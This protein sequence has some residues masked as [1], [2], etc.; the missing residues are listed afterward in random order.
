[1]KKR[2]LAAIMSLCMVVSLLPVSA[3]AAGNEGEVT[4][5]KTWEQVDG[6]KS[7]T[8]EITLSVQGEPIPTTTESAADVVLV[9]DN[10]GSMA[11]GV[12]EPCGTPNEEFEKHTFLGTGYYECPNCHAIYVSILGFASLPDICTGEIGGEARIITAQKVGK[13][14]ASS[15]L[16]TGQNKMAVIGFSHGN[17][18][19][20]ANDQRAIKVSQ[21]LTND[22]DEINEAIDDMEANGGTNYSAALQQAYSWL[23]E[24]SDADKENRPAYV[25]FISDGAPGYSGESVNDPDWNGSKQA[26]ALKA[27]GVTVYTIG[28]ALSD[29][30]SQYLESLASEPTSEHYLNVTGTNYAEELEKILIEWADK[31]NSIPAGKNAVM[32]DVINSEYFE[33][34]QGSLSDGLEIDI[35]SDPTGNTL[36]WDIGNIPESGQVSF[37]IK[38]KDELL[39]EISV[40]GQKVLTNDGVTLTYDSNLPEGGS[41]KLDE[42]VIGEPE[43]TIYGTK[44][45][46]PTFTSSKAPVT[47]GT[48]T[49]TAPDQTLT[50][51][52]NYIAVSGNATDGYTASTTQDTATV[53]YEVTVTSDM[54]GSV[55]VTDTGAT[56]VGANLETGDTV[57]TSD[58]PY[59]VTFADA[60][61]AKLYFSVGATPT[62]DAADVVENTA[63]VGGEA[64]DSPDVTVTQT[65]KTAMVNKTVTV[66]HNSGTTGDAVK[67]G[68]VLTYTITV[69]NTGT[70]AGTFT[71]TDTFNGTNAPTATEPAG[72]GW[73]GAANSWTNTWSLSVAA[74]ASEDITYSYTV[75][76]QDAGKSITNGVTVD[77]GLEDGSDPDT[78]TDVTGLTL[79]YDDNVDD[80]SVTGMPEQNPV[81]GIVYGTELAVAP[82]P[83]RDGYVFLGWDTDPR[84]TTADYEIG[85]SIIIT[86]DTP[87]YAIWEE[88]NLEAQVVKTVDPAT[89]PVAV[90][91]MLTYTI[92]V[93]NTGNTA[94]IFHVKDTFNGS[95]A[96]DGDGWAQVG[97]G[98]TH[99]WKTAELA[100][101]ASEKITYTYTVQ[102]EDAGKTLR[103]YALVTN[104]SKD[105]DSV[106][107]TE[108]EVENEGI[109]TLTYDDNVAEEEIAVP[110][111][112]SGLTYHQ[113][114]SVSSEYP[115]WTD[116]S[117]DGWNTQADGEGTT[118]Q[119]GDPIVIT[120]NTT[121]YAMWSPLEDPEVTLEKTVTR[122]GSAV[123]EAKVGDVLTYTITVKTT[124]G[125][126]WGYHFEDTFKGSAKPVSPKGGLLW[127]QNAD[128]T[129][130]AG[131][132]VDLYETDT[133]TFTYT[134]TV[135]LADAGSD[136]TNEVVG[137]NGGGEASTLTPVSNL[138]LIYDANG[139]EFGDS[140]FFP[141]TGITKEQAKGYELGKEQYYSDP[142]HEPSAD[143]SEIVFIGWSTTKYGTIY[144]AG[145]QLP[146]TT[147]TVKMEKDTTVYAVWGEDTNGDEVADATQ[148]L[149]T[150][151]KIT[152]Y[153]GGEGY[154]YALGDADQDIAG[155]P[156]SGLPEPGY[157]IVLPYEVNEELKKVPG[158]VV[159]DKGYVNLADHLTFSYN[160]ED[161]SRVWELT[162]Y[163]PDGLTHLE[164]GRYIY[165]ILPATADT[166]GD[167]VEESI[168][169]RLVF[170]DEDEKET[171]SD[172]F[173]FSANDLY[174][175]FQMTIYDGGLDQAQIQATVDGTTEAQ[176]VGVGT[177]EL[178]IRGTTDTVET[179]AVNDMENDADGF[180]V[181]ADAGNV[182]YVNGSP[183]QVQESD[184]R[185]LA[186]DLAMEEDS[187]TEKAMQ[188]AADKA[189]DTAL[190]NPQYEFKYLDLVD[191]NNGNAYVTLNQNSEEDVVTVNW[192]MPANADPDTIHVVHF[193]GLD[194]EFDISEL[195][196]LLNSDEVTAIVYSMEDG[197]TVG[198]DSVSFNTSTFSPFVLVYETKAEQPDPTPDPDP[199]NGDSGS[200]NDNDSDP[201][202]N[203]SIELDVNGGDDD[204]TF[205]V[206]LTDRNGDDLENNFYYNGDYTGTIGSGDEIT[207]EGGEKI[208]IR[209]LPEGT[210]YEVIIETADGYTY[211]IDGEEGV[212]HTGMNEAEFTATRTVPVADPSVTGVSRWLNTTDHIAYLTG[213]PGGTFGPDNNMT[214]AEVAQMFYALLNNKNVTIT[215]TFPDVPAD[216][217]YATAVNTL[218]SLGMVSGDENGNYRPDDPITRAEFCVIALAFAY[219]PEN[220]VCYFGDV[221]RSD[222]FYTYV[223]QAASYGWIGGYTNGNFGPNDRITRAQVTTIVNN[224]LGRAADRDYVI[225]HQADLVQF[226][227][228]TRAH[229]GYFQI[230]EATNAHDYTKSNGTENWR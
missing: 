205:T 104:A 226:S 174:A 65:E 57:D 161:D 91:D 39:P 51:G 7:N 196:E 134:Y 175:K 183:I 146:E 147:E 95:A 131:M 9:V 222:W 37:Q 22:V 86:A 203:L 151:A 112:V 53:L 136:I 211:V 88:T 17:N 193:D 80:D 229:W 1:M 189:I 150:P 34:V 23:D 18:D 138:T 217:W 156:S 109:Y 49:L 149:I 20:G 218:A 201:T 124:E 105:P 77:A 144:E 56:Y 132:T 26:T 52:T 36:V 137:Q 126:V 178:V 43:V 107:E 208:V 92:T 212:I 153:E 29:N 213:Y 163:D 2:L 195:D 31:I 110:A 116:Y 4:A 97:G 103:N 81:T 186:D 42:D 159:N 12:G 165:R 224:M 55:T 67:P 187:E 82:A 21:G 47:A 102:P 162:T 191:Y 120:G 117:F 209:N 8:F 58:N 25:V 32:T 41:V 127:E 155:Q 199:G 227:D 207:L 60:G 202:G 169:V 71:V 140:G 48:V 85:E 6:E 40:D 197:L 19:G 141:V 108:T 5:T 190:D 14:F 198:T 194:R 76:A 99:S 122:N 84:A 176:D 125:A 228:L 10:S 123:T 128:G 15:I 221:S 64:V 158:V 96:P 111:A 168:P 94:A 172:D 157:Y 115:I 152:I 113:T 16:S 87:L 72:S 100:V 225:D 214:R 119:P 206:I 118:Y 215:K 184:I 73:A 45:A 38:V 68:D 171:I 160:D 98:W 74:G 185:L 170:T 200:D 143:G 89:S 133:K 130:T 24:R 166:N 33:L 114:V 145:Q 28:I 129:W 139:G 179:V 167:G 180:T 216:A 135:Q 75:V 173:T 142:T 154:D 210:R 69:Q 63:M 3:F 188:D 30:D 204:F 62:A 93:T 223:A 54:A 177:G 79:T 13:E 27:D 66:T 148:V 121:L 101:G 220:A 164:D 181:T 61:T 44:P 83:S 182:Y 219:E 192:P 70:E 106:P 11:S 46:G 230:M 78:E 59:T 50:Q 35:E 90:G